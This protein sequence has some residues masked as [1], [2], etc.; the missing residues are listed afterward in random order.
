MT[1]RHASARSPSPPAALPALLE[2]RVEGS[3]AVLDLLRRELPA[4]VAAAQALRDRIGSGGTLYTAGNGGSAAQA[5][6]LA[7]EL[8]GR[9]RSDRRA[10]PAVCLCADPAA[11]TCIANDFGYEQVFA[12]QCS[13]LLRPGDALLVLSTSGASSNLVA[14]LHEARRRRALSVGLLGGT[15]GPCRELCELA[16]VIGSRDTAHVQ[17]AHQVIVH[18]ICEALEG[19]TE[20]VA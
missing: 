15:G 4:V 20:N 16:V 13:A 5:L 8:L 17:E 9:Y 3:L 18:L 1:T 6:H 12:R 11:L 2:R 10:L 19:I 7:E 14:A